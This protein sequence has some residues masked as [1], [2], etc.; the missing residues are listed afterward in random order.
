DAFEAAARNIEN[1]AG[2]AYNIGG[3]PA[4]AVSLLEVVHFIERR[5]GS[6]LL[7]RTAD[8][9]PGD[10]RVYVSDIRRAG[11]ELGWSPRIGWEAGLCGLHDWIAGNR[12]QLT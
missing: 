10:Q 3:G 4:N 11:R 12:A 1:A 7:Y 5:R 2:A 6:R 8:T 9:R